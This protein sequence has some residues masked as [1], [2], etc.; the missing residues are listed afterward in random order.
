MPEE[1]WISYPTQLWLLYEVATG[2]VESS[3]SR[4]E[5]TTEPFGRTVHDFCVCKSPSI[6]M[7]VKLALAMVSVARFIGA[8][9]E[10]TLAL[11]DWSTLSKLESPLTFENAL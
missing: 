1:L 8:L 9:S 7:N 3:A 6:E 10:K 11:L 5:A 2:V 4:V